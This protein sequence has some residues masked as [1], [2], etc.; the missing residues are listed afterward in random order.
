[1]DR[2][3]CAKCERVSLRHCERQRSNPSRGAKK[4]HGLLRFARN[5]GVPTSATSSSVMAG[6]VPAIHVLQYFDMDLFETIAK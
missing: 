5:D 6:L 1:L 2:R 3:D 4:E